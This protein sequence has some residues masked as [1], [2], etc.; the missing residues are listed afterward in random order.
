MPVLTL[1]FSADSTKLYYGNRTNKINVINLDEMIQSAPILINA[2]EH[3]QLREI[4][5]DQHNKHIVAMGLSHCYLF[6]IEQK[7]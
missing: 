6:N 1:S 5:I 3:S 2:Q 4:V 7:R